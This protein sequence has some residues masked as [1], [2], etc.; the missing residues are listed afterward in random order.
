MGRERATHKIIIIVHSFSSK[1]LS[2]KYWQWELFSL[3]VISPVG[4]LLSVLLWIR[5]KR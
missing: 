5:K 4:G 1:W 2:F 3:A